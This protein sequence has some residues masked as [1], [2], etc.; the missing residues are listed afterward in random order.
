MR[1][2][3]ILFVVSLLVIVA[4][5]QDEFGGNIKSDSIVQKPANS[6]AFPERFKF[7]IGV[8]WGIDYGGLLGVKVTYAPI[9]H[10]AMFIAMGYYVVDIGFQAG[11]IG[12]I[13]PKTTS[14]TYRPYG[15]LM[16]GTNR[17]LKIHDDP[18]L[19]KA[20]VGLTPGI[21]C[22][23]R[24]GKKRKHGINVDAGYTIPSRRYKDDFAYFENHLGYIITEGT[25]IVLSIGYHF[26]L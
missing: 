9:R 17:G 6:A 4:H 1:K 3:A 14:K 21:G 13:V 7:D 25:Y 26:E 5:A 23:M 20:Y 16:V 15:K 24:F 2:F 18:D 8:G 11:I 12:Y 22:E 19:S 10:M